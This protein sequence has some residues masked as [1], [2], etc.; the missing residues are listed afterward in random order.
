MPFTVPK[1]RWTA[2]VQTATIGATEADIEYLIGRIR[3]RMADSPVRGKLAWMDAALG[4]FVR[5]RDAGMLSEQALC[6]APLS[7]GSC[8]QHEKRRSEESCKS[9]TRS[10]A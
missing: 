1:E 4:K 2:A 6:T 10:S 7:A 5:A 3:E 9:R 8:S